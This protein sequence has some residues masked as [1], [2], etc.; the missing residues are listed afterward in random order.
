M[1]MHALPPPPLTSSLVTLMICHLS[2]A[3]SRAAPSIGK[4]LKPKA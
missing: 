3:L 4:E 2:F 1:N